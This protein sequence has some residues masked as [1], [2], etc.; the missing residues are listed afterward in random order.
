MRT[1]WLFF[2]SC[3]EASYSQLLHFVGN[4]V[5]KERHDF[6]VA[7]DMGTKEKDRGGNV[8]MDESLFTVRFRE[9]TCKSSPKL[10]LLQPIMKKGVSKKLQSCKLG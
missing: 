6:R 2:P 4:T 9:N 7:L 1:E 8:E 3:H 5:E 10:K